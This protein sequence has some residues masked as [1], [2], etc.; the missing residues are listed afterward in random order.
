MPDPAGLPTID[1]LTVVDGTGRRRSG[2]QVVSEPRGARDDEDDL[3]Q[4]IPPGNGFRGSPGSTKS[5]R[6]RNSPELHEAAR[7]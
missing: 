1:E 4:W 6:Q 5:V 2:G 3:F 7:G